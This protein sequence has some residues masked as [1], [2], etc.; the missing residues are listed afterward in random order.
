MKKVI[1]LSAPKVA[2]VIYYLS[3]LPKDMAVT[4]TGSSFFF[5]EVDKECNEVNIT[6]LLTEEEKDNA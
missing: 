6:D 5:M 1:D 3:S 2:D 4:S